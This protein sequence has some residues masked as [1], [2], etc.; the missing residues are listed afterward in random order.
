M[1]VTVMKAKEKTT[2]FNMMNEQNHCKS[3]RLLDFYSLLLC[4]NFNR[5]IFEFFL[6]NEIGSISCII[7]RRGER[8]RR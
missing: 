8:L 5:N 3:P 4:S 7:A 2:V 6:S 1:A